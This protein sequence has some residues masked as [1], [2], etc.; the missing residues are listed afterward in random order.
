MCVVPCAAQV[1][2]SD[3]AW[4]SVKVVMMQHP[5]AVSA[6]SLG[7]HIISASSTA[8]T[9]GS[10]AGSRTGS[11]AGAG[12]GV[13][14]GGSHGDGYA[15]ASGG[16]GGGPAPDVVSPLMELLPN[17]LAKRM[18]KSLSTK[19][20]VGGGQIRRSIRSM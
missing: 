3:G 4:E 10:G 2:L 8:V 14:A 12:A 17:L 20:Q 9:A 7:T 11:G 16:L 18:F 6:I 15:G 5:G 19:A 13:V 1:V